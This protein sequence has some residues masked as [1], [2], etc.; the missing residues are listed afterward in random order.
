MV[1]ILMGFELEAKQR[2]IVDLKIKS[3]THRLF[4]P[5]AGNGGL[6]SCFNWFGLI[7]KVSKYNI[8]FHI[9]QKKVA[10]KD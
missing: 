3:E 5:N 9:L 2:S 4:W 1:E 8:I 7:F 10:K 6:I